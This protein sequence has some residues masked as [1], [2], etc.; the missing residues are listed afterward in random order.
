MPAF[1]RNSETCMATIP[2]SMIAITQIQPRLRTSLSI[3]IRG[4]A[5]CGAV[6][7][8]RSGPETRRGAIGA[9]LLRARA[10]A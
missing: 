7:T 8:R 1:R 3:G 6:G 4:A 5:G 9:R 10:A 2:P